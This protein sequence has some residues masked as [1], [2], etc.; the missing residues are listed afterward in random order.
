MLRPDMRPRPSTRLEAHVRDYWDASV[1]LARVDNSHRDQGRH[2]TLPVAVAILAELAT[3]HPLS[4]L[5]RAAAD[6]LMSFAPATA[7]QLMKRRSGESK[8]HS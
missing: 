5:R 7:A 6:R 8:V 3:A 2:L 4:R 1:A